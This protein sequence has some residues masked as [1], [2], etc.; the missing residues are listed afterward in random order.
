MSKKLRS[1]LKQPHT[2]VWTSAFQI[3]LHNAGEGEGIGMVIHRAGC[4]YSFNWGLRG[5]GPWGPQ[6]CRSSQGFKESSA[7]A[8]RKFLGP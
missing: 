2:K 5:A 7:T 3:C 1:I 8:W 4:Y 6:P